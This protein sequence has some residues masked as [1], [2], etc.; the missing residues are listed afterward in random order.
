MNFDKEERKFYKSAGIHSYD[1]IDEVMEQTDEINSEQDLR[2]WIDRNLYELSPEYRD[3]LF[4]TR[5]TFVI[6][7]ESINQCPECLKFFDDPDELEIHKNVKHG[8]KQNTLFEQLVPQYL[9]QRNIMIEDQNFSLPPP[10]KHADYNEA[11][12]NWEGMWE[13]E[14]LRLLKDAMLDTEYAEYS[15]SKLPED[16][17]SKIYFTL[18]KYAT[19]RKGDGRE[20]EQNITDNGVNKNE[21]EG[22]FDHFNTVK[23]NEKIPTICPTC[24]TDFPDPIQ[25]YRHLKNE[26]NLTDEDAMAEAQK[27]MEEWTQKKR[28]EYGTNA[29][30][31]I[32]SWTGLEDLANG[33]T[34]DRLDNLS[35]N[36]LKDLLIQI[37]R[38]IELIHSSMNE[39]EHYGVQNDNDKARLILAQLELGIA[40]IESKLFDAKARD[41]KRDSYSPLEDYM[42][43]PHYTLESMLKSETKGPYEISTRNG[44]IISQYIE[45]ESEVQVII[46]TYQEEYSKDHYG[47]GDAIVVKD[48][49]GNDVSRLFSNAVQNWEKVSIENIDKELNYIQR[50]LGLI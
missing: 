47:S 25:L 2:D 30:E 1:S 16:V 4:E 12:A 38:N 24:D 37:E 39:K 31:Y 44:D 36:E 28:K 40:E 26:Y 9:D 20:N 32:M 15:F 7:Y 46:D 49:I 29:K 42:N 14:R 11:K 48:S 23:D 50:G 45:D 33:L 10:R 43:N 27:Q 8:G 5:K 41:D 17:R 35:Y 21:I 19:T 13:A 18:Q 34:S 22:Q 3:Y 6:S